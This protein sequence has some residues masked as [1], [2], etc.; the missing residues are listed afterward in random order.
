[1][2]E[3][4]W[5]DKKCSLCDELASCQTEMYLQNSEPVPGME[6]LCKECRGKSSLP[7]NTAIIVTD[8]AEP[9]CGLMAVGWFEA[10]QLLSEKSEPGERHYLCAE[11]AWRWRQSLGEEWE[12]NCQSLEPNGQETF[13][14]PQKMPRDDRRS[15]I[16]SEQIN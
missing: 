2:A 5:N 6:Y 12:I 14:E 9:D 10:T 1:M 4:R 11:H 15:V 8:C 3:S 16:W 7:P 13:S